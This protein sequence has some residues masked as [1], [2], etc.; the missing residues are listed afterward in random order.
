MHQLSPTG[1]ARHI[2]AGVDFE[3]ALAKKAWICGTSGELTA[4]L[5]DIERRYNVAYGSE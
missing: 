2:A 1:V 3:D 4:Y 5:K